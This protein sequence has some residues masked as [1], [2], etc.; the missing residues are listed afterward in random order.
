MDA[1]EAVEST[2]KTLAL[3]RCWLWMAVECR[4]GEEEKEKLQRL[5][6]SFVKDV[7]RVVHS[8]EAFVVWLPQVPYLA[9][10][11]Y[12]QGAVEMSQKF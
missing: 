1:E 2:V 3:L 5:F 8:E 12:I 9:Y 7:E 11:L 10:I 6:H 4:C